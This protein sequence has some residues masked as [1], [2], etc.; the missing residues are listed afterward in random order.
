[1][2]ARPPPS[3]SM[4]GVAAAQGDDVAWYPGGGPHC[5]RRPEFPAHHGSLGLIAG[6]EGVAHLPVEAG[7]IGNDVGASLVTLKNP[8]WRTS[9]SKAHTTA[10]IPR[11]IAHVRWCCLSATRHCDPGLPA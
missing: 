1:M 3:Q 10:E 8:F 4:P 6:V 2:R 5:A 7:L 9:G 11:C